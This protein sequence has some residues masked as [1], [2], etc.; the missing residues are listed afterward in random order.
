MLRYIATHLVLAADVQEV[1]VA[2]HNFLEARDA[3][4]EE[5]WQGESDDVTPD[6]Q[7]GV[8]SDDARRAA[9]AARRVRLVKAFGLAWVDGA[10]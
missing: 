7:V 2:F 3:A 10:E 1:T 4:Y 6:G 9:G 8:Q 5:E